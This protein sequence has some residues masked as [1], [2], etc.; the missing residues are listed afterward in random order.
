[1]WGQLSKVYQDA[2][3][4]LQQV[5]NRNVL[6]LASQNVFEG[7]A[8]AIGADLSY[9]FLAYLGVATDYF[10]GLANQVT[11]GLSTRLINW[12]GL[13]SAI[14]PNSTAYALGSYTGQIVT[15]ALSLWPPSAGILATIQMVSGVSAGVE[16]MVNGDTVGGLTTI[17]LAFI[18]LGLSALSRCPVTALRVAGTAGLTFGGLYSA[19]TNLQNAYNN[20]TNP[21]GD[22]IQGTLNLLQ[23]GVAIYGVSKTLDGA[24]FTARMWMENEHGRTQAFRV[25]VGDKLWARNELD[26]TGPIELREVEE[27]FERL[28]RI[29]NVHVA[30]EILETTAEHPFYVVGRGWI[31]A[32]QLQIG[33]L[34]MTRSGL[35][36]PV[37]GV[38]DSGAWNRCTTGGSV[39]TI[40]TSSAR[41]RMGR[42]FRRIMRTEAAPLTTATARR[43]ANTRAQR[44]SV[45]PDRRISRR[46]GSRRW[47]SK[48]T[49][50]RL[51]RWQIAGSR[52][53]RSRT[54]Y[55]RTMGHSLNSRVGNTLAGPSNCRH[56]RTWDVG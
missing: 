56:K 32:C 1:M 10:A 54:G 24:C 39:N 26:P 29:W 11:A 51:I 27:V 4:K 19:S 40:L 41:L 33:D 52:S 42:A 18:S 34:L 8:N 2:A 37:E 23:A 7:A 31:A 35:L 3:A 49:R 25:K 17:G 15:I 55:A 16:A 48:R 36:V 20:F 21:N 6:T 46:R 28:A 14:N 45:Q 30:G 50:R 9:N 13:S 22:P 43:T 12:A 53:R 47:A 44:P 38:A 5:L